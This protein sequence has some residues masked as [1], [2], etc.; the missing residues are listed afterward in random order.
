MLKKWLQKGFISR[1]T[2]FSLFSSDFIL[3]KAYDLPKILLKNPNRIIV[4]SINTALY[5][6]ASFQKI[7]STNL[8]YDDKHVRNSFDLYRV[9]FSK[10][11]E[12]T[13]ILISL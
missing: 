6:L 1:H 10:K 9:L 7:I 5:P 2:Y 12:D 8:T 3:P 4:S 13:D 11:I